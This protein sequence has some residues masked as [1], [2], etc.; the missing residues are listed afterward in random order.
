V[1]LQIVSGDG[2]DLA[3]PGREFG[4]R[5][6]IDS[7]ATGDA[8]V[9]SEAGSKVLVLRLSNPSEGIKHLIGAVS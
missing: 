2:D 6:L 8:I 9:L 1:Y 7:Q 3:I 5:Q 4:Y